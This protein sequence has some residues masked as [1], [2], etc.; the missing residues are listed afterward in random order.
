VCH[1]LDFSST[2][3]GQFFAALGFNIF[4]EQYAENGTSKANRLRV[5]WHGADDSAV[6]AVLSAFADYVEAKNALQAG[7]LDVSR[8]QLERVRSIA[9]D[10]GS[11]GM[12][13][14]PD[15]AIATQEAVGS[16]LRIDIHPD[17]Y[18]HI[19]PYIESSDH[20]HA[21][22]E[23]Y[24]VVRAKLRDLTGEER[25]TAIFNENAQKLR[26]RYRLLPRF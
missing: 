7:A 12:Q 25:A 9:A 19:Q 3:F 26:I 11:A 8:E 21:V 14:A 16:E 20:F 1:V 15:T 13:L 6:S 22:E 5:F 24:K 10:L 18:S 4:D 23:A 17:V 2:S